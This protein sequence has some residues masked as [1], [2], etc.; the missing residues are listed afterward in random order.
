D[1]STRTAAEQ[2]VRHLAGRRTLLLVDNCEHVLE[3]T[4]HLLAELL[5]A[6][7]ELSV[8]TTS[9][10]PLGIAG[11][12]IHALGPMDVP[13]LDQ[14]DARRPIDEAETV[15]LM[16]DRARALVPG[17]EVDDDN[18]EAIVQLCERL[19]GM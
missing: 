13:R 7:E 9:R 14:P 4:A 10:E 11:E 5:D 16:V 1:Q 15:R 18:R 3:A 8:I 2:I 19:D 17:F 6:V 12:Q